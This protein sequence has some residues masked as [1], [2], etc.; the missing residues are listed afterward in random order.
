MK[1]IITGAAGFIGSH[2]VD[3][4]LKKKAQIIGIDNLE[5]GS[6]ANLK[7]AINKK[8]SQQMICVI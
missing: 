3:Y 7:D 5:D 1:I 8:L 4:I 6:I 2:L